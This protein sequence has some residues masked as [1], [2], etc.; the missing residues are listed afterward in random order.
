MNTEIECKY[1]TN[2]WVLQRRIKIIKEEEFKNNQNE[3]ETP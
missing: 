2:Q 3:I 1:I